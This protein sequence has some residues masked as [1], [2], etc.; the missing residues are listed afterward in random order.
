MPLSQKA[1]FIVPAASAWTGGYMGS[2]DGKL[3]MI[4]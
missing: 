4:E 1:V 2:R 3:G